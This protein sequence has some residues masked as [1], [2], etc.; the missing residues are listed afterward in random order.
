MGISMYSHNPVI[1]RALAVE[2]PTLIEIGF[3]PGDKSGCKIYACKRGG[4]VTIIGMHSRVY[5]CGREPLVDPVT[6]L[7]SPVKGSSDG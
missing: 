3:I 4:L 5:G 1:K 7:D 6:I 2:T